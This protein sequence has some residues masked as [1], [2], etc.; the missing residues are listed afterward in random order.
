MGHFDVVGSVRASS[1]S[2]GEHVAKRRVPLGRSDRLQ[3]AAG[4]TEVGREEGEKCRMLQALHC[5]RTGFVFD[6]CRRGTWRWLVQGS[7]HQ[8]KQQERKRTSVRGVIR[9]AKCTSS[10]RAKKQGASCEALPSGLMSRCCA[11]LVHQQLDRSEWQGKVASKQPLRTWRDWTLLACRHDI[12]RLR[13]WSVTLLEVALYRCHITSHDPGVLYPAVHLRPPDDGSRDRTR[14]GKGYIATMIVHRQE[15]RIRRTRQTSSCDT[16]KSLTLTR[17]H[18]FN[19]LHSWKQFVFL[20]TDLVLEYASSNP[21]TQAF[22]IESR[23]PRLLCK[24]WSTT[25]QEPGLSDPHDGGQH[26][27]VSGPYCSNCG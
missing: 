18:P 23:I 26:C 16:R 21:S 8:D 4:C 1:S 25:E 2:R 6:A 12:E 14:G 24:Y 15:A 5:S 7:V 3:P 19:F 11:P 20:I 17:L 10:T 22:A 13:G 9:K 27:E